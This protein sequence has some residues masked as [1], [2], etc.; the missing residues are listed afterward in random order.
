MTGRSAV[1]PAEAFG[2]GPVDEEG[3][4]DDLR[5]REIAPETGVQAVH[6]VIAHDEEMS[7][8]D[9]E[10]VARLKFSDERMAE[11]TVLFVGQVLV[12]GLV[13]GVRAA[14]GAEE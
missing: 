7:G 12:C 14:G 9:G 2:D 6:R 8:L 5:G 11:V 13:F 10:F 1:A 4:A 3:L